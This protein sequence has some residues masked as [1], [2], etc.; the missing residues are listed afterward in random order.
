MLWRL[1]GGT[2]AGRL[3]PN[4]GSGSTAEGLQRGWKVLKTPVHMSL[5]TRVVVPRKV[6]AVMLKCPKVFHSSAPSA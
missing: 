4:P 2:P 6:G 3:T 1:Q 5:V